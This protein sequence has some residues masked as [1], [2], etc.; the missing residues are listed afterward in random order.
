VGLGDFDLALHI[1]HAAFHL[2]LCVSRGIG[3]LLG[4]APNDDVILSHDVFFDL[5]EGV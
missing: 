3:K 1:L 5:S 2:A 4:F